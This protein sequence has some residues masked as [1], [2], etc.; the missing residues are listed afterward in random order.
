MMPGL[1]ILNN[2][3]NE[4]R[5]AMKL[6]D[7]QRVQSL[8]SIRNE[9]QLAEKEKQDSLTH[10]EVIANLTK[11]AKSR[12]DSI[13]GFRDANRQDLVSREQL[14]LELITSYLPEMMDRA[15]I[16]KEALAVIAN[17]A[18]LDQ[19]QTGKIIGQLM[20]NLKGKADGRLVSEVV[21]ELM[22]EVSEPEDSEG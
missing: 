12:R 8:R 4:E 3:L 1:D 5:K 11:Q 20:G 9:L 10:D 2:L 13:E 15:S 16:Q 17:F 7:S 19:S 6:R 18:S 22:Q 14:E 21:K